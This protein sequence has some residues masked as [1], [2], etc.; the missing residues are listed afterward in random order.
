MR[1]LTL[2]DPLG[3]QTE[4]RRRGRGCRSG[5]SVHGHDEPGRLGSYDAA[6]PME[7]PAPGNPTQQQNQDQQ[8][9]DP[10]L[11]AGTKGARA[12]AWAAGRWD[13]EPVQ[14]TADAIT[15]ITVWTILMDNALKAR[16]R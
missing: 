3:H 13:D 12:V 4:R 15:A 6:T 1:V 8:R 9:Q 14:A 2:A 11:V 10:V 16:N 7:R 5:L